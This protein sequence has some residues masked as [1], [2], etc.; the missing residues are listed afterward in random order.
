MEDAHKQ[1]EE[2]V[3][4]RKQRG[5]DEELRRSAEWVGVIQMSQII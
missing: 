3:A 2:A 4:T 5:V 1:I